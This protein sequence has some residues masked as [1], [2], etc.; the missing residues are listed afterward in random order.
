MEIEKIRKSVIKFFERTG[1]KGNLPKSLY[2]YQI[3][4]IISIVD[5]VFN[6]R[7]NEF[8][9][10]FSRQ[11]GKTE[12]ISTAVSYIALL[13][14]ILNKGIKI[15]IYAPSLEQAQILFRRAK[16]RL[17]VAIADIKKLNPEIDNTT[18]IL[19][20]DGTE[21]KA[22]SADKTARKTG[23]TN[24]LMVFDE[25]QDISDLVLENFIF[26]MGAATNATRVYIG[27]AG[28]NLCYFYDAINSDHIPDKNKFILTWE[29][30]AKYN[31]NYGKYV[32]NEK[33]RLGEGS[34]AFRRQYLLEWIFSEGQAVQMAD[35]KELEKLGVEHIITSTK[36]KV[37]AGLDIAKHIDYTVLTVI[38]EIN[39]KPQIIY[40][41]EFPL[42]TDWTVQLNEVTKIISMRFPNLQSLVIDAT[43]EGDPVYSWLKQY[44]MQYGL[45]PAKI[46]PFQFSPARKD[47]LY[48][49]YLNAIYSH[50]FGI[51]KENNY[52]KRK[53]I[54]EHIQLQ[55]EYK[56]NGLMSIHHP[57][58]EN[59]HDDYPDSAALAWWG[60]VT[61]PAK[62]SLVIDENEDEDF[63]KLPL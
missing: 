8:V 33:R 21:I 19:F 59:A 47:A 18:T 31:K 54:N 14:L 36:A 39:N 23:H 42:E 28:F 9:I 63:M 35:L 3:Q 50:K 17:K 57:D 20:P 62:L 60:Y 45:S 34:E 38:A 10:H 6:K 26:P 11:S 4:P 44:F 15:G 30:A 41:H 51:P 48:K 58:K 24:D 37:Y 2:D 40:W 27:V 13:S 49:E 56:S 53:F 29:E 61:R 5:D 25:M 22:I 46:I 52:N 16:L 43:G 1:Q 7:G 12:A 32:E 55:K